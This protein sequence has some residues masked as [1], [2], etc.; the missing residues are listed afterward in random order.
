MKTRLTI[1][2]ALGALVTLAGC[3]RSDVAPDVT[4]FD[5]QVRAESGATRATVNG[6]TGSF[7]WEAGDK[8]AIHLNTGYQEATLSAA[9]TTTLTAAAGTVRDGYA[10][11][12]S[13]VAEGTATAPSVKLPSAYDITGSLSSSSAALPMVALNDPDSDILY[14][15]HVGG[16]VRVT[17]VSVP[18]GTRSVQVHFPGSRITGSFP[19]SDPAS[20]APTI[21]TGTVDTDDIV[22]FTVSEAGLAAAADV[23]LNLPVPCGTYAGGLT[24]NVIPAD[25]SF[26]NTVSGSIVLDR[27]QGVQVRVN[28]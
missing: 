27:A 24:V 20:T 6:S 7:A 16:L 12:P 2:A 3:S 15:R 28:P 17:V 22:T 14:F 19:V 4:T 18:A 26:P 25:A 21:V 5:L 10:I 9:G 1:I 13:A 8:I 11:F 23:V